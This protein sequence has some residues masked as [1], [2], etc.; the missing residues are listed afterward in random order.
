MLRNTEVLMHDFRAYPNFGKY[1][2]QNGV[3]LAAI[4]DV[5]LLDTVAQGLQTAVYLWDH[6][7]F[8]G[9]VINQLAGLLRLESGD[10]P[11]FPIQHAF[12]VCQED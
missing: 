9:L 2:Q 10:Q 6:S 4:D 7:P 11:S 5:S 8:D 3:G 1:F 12:C